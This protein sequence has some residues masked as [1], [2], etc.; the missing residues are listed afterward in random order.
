MHNFDKYVVQV[1]LKTKADS[2]EKQEYSISTV[3]TVTGVRA[4][5]PSVPRDVQI[6]F[7]TGDDAVKT[8]PTITWDAPPH[9]WGIRV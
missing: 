3:A 9:A 8:V 5:K 4:E 6:T 1:F 7:P 2:D